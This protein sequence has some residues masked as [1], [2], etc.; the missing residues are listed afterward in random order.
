MHLKHGSLESV[1]L[2]AL[3]KLEQQGNYSNTVLDIY[4]SLAQSEENKR[5]YTTVKT[6]MD[7]LV[8]KK[9][10]MRF[11]QGRKFCYRS[12]YSN[13]EM[14][15]KALIDVA[16]KYCEGNF[17]ILVNAV[18]ALYEISIQDKKDNLISVQ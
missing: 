6:V 10:I 5:A 7:R 8:L 11:K 15:S 4:N 14:L 12:L 18:N 3:W 13:K 17:E 9:Q 1:I 2:T 16:Q